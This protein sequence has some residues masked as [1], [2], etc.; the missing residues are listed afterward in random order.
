MRTDLIAFILVLVASLAGAWLSSSRHQR[1]M[2][3]V[4]EGFTRSGEVVIDDSPF[5]VPIRDY[6]RIV[7]GP[8][9]AA[10]VLL[11]LINSNRIVMVTQYWNST[12]DQKFRLDHVPIINKTNGIESILEMEP[13]LVIVNGL[14]N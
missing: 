12:S 9:V 2:A 10:D 4:E 11:E 8:T 13:D 7:C 14:S 3:T 6:Q 1:L 5:S